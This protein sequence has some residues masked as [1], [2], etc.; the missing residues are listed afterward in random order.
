MTFKSIPTFTETS[1]QNDYFKFT[2]KL[3]FYPDFKTNNIT[4]LY[5][6]NL[7]ALL[8]LN[9][10]NCFQQNYLYGANGFS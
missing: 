6:F 8:E 5:M 3:F 1:K 4:N 2:K 9:L 7:S 10:K